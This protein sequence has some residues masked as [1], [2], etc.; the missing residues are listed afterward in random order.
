MVQ[1][2][3]AHRRWEAF[4]G[5]SHDSK[6]MIFSVRK[7]SVFQ[8]KTKLE[9]FMAANVSEQVP[10]FRIEGNWFESACA[11]YAGDTQNIIAQVSH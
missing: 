5:E 7:S 2:M 1:V 6:D 8:M 4:R 11:I 3:T 10:D 9:V